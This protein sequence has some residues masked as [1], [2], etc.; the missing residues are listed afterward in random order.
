[1]EFEKR[2]A[3]LQARMS[4]SAKVQLENQESLLSIDESRRQLIKRVIDLEASL[5]K[6]SSSSANPGVR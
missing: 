4:D 6:L 3:A 5:G 2:I 1:Q